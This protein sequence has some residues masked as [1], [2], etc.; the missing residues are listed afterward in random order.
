MREW[1]ARRDSNSRP[2]APEAIALSSLSYGRTLA[3]YTY[4]RW[5]VFRERSVAR[6]RRVSL[7]E[8]F[9]SS[10]FSLEIFD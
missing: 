3:N 6:V 10:D 7:F 1:C 5:R 4:L 2:I 9:Y 8:T